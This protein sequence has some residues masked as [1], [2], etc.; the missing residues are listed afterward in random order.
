LK[1]IR[2][3]VRQE[4]IPYGDYLRIQEDLRSRREELILVCEHPPV[5]T[6]GVKFQNSSLIQTSGDL[7]KAGIEFVKTGRG[8]DATAHE[9][10]QIVFYPH[11]DLRKRGLNIASFFH[12]LLV[13]V[14]TALAQVCAIHTFIREEAPG[15]YV[16]GAVQ[17]GA[18]I[19]SIGVQFKGFFTSH[20]IAVNFTNDLSTFAMIHPCGDP[21][22]SVTS[23]WHLNQGAPKGLFVDVAVQELR[24]HFDT[25]A[26][27]NS[28]D[29]QGPGSS[30]G[31]A[32]D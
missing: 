9:P 14:Q 11:V 21:S 8:G 20:G 15:L 16:E 5:I 18:K 26:A 17:R 1:P 12:G 3:I 30:V 22:Q 2:V 7:A 10:G 27:G 28:S 31:R 6:A 29:F 23:A 25:E 24:K 32:A 4:L 13:S 19:A